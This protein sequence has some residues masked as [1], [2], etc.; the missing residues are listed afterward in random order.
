M[1]FIIEQPLHIFLFSDDDERFCV[2][3]RSN[4]RFD[5]FISLL[6]YGIIQSC[7]EVATLFQEDER[8]LI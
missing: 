4:S 8:F 5:N 3:E 7:Q 6:I 2:K 1:F